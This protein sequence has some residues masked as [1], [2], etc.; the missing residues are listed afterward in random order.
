MDL[1]YDVMQK[2]GDE[3]ER[4]VLSEECELLT[5]WAVDSWLSLGVIVQCGTRLRWTKEHVHGSG[6]GAGR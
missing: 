5:G 6:A 4:D 2:L 3:C 1:V